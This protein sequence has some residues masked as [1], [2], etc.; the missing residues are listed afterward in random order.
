MNI[1]VF[2]VGVFLMSIAAVHCG[3]VSRILRTVIDTLAKEKATTICGGIGAIV[4]CS[5]VV[6]LCFR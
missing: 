4:Y 2:S 5:W 3:A 1:F 6:W